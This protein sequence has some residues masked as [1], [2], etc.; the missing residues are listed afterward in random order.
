MKHTETDLGKSL[1]E[2]GVGFKY[3]YNPQNNILSI[4]TKEQAPLLN[5]ELKSSLLKDP[6][7]YIQ[8]IDKAAQICALML[9]ANKTHDLTDI[10]DDSRL[11]SMLI[12]SSKLAHDSYELQLMEFKGF[13]RRFCAENRLRDLQIKRINGRAPNDRFF[14]AKIQTKQN[15]AADKTPTQSSCRSTFK[16]P[17]KHHDEKTIRQP[18]AQLHSQ[19]G[20]PLPK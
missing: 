19:A 12:S 8:N 14:A 9:S 5:L 1:A 11:I 2:T 10:F 20:H 18:Q 15:S 6:L 16:N 4:T 17:G 3:L 13:S 7:R